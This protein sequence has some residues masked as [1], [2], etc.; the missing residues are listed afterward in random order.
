M[1]AAD[2]KSLI[3]SRSI[4]YAK[5]HSLS[6]TEFKT[7][8]VF[9]NVK[10]NFLPSSYDCILK[11][12]EW[13]DRLNKRHPQVHNAKEMQS[14]NSSDA[15]LMNIFC[16]PKINSWKGIYRLFGVSDINSKF[17]MKPELRLKSGRGDRTE[18]D[19]AFENII[20]EAK[21][22]ETDFTQKS[23]SVVK[24]YTDVEKIFYFNHLPNNGE[25]IFHYQI[26]RNIIASVQLNK[27]HILICD[28]RR[29]DMIRGYYDVVKCI[30]DISIRKN[31]SIIFWQD[32]FGS[33]GR[34]LKQFLS[35]KYGIGD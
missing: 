26:I 11:K 28:D 19:L 25:N 2:L 35:D 33:V 15:L 13:S 17:G 30:K 32:I 1:N 3:R 31:C 12:K 4:E 9:D 24:N 8:I 22:T 10:D 7:A 5:K 16:H 6:Y 20:I 27:R 23:V 14:S 29:G 18:I 21:L 34:E